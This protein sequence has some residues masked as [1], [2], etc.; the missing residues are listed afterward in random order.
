MTVELYQ[1]REG[2][3]PA[4]GINARWC[5]RKGVVEVGSGVPWAPGGK[6]EMSQGVLQI[7]DLRHAWGPVGF[8]KKNERCF[9]PFTVWFG[10]YTQ[11]GIAKWICFPVQWTAQ[12][13]LSVAK[14]TKNCKVLCHNSCQ[15]RCRNFR[16]ELSCSRTCSR[17][18]IL[19]AQTQQRKKWF[20]SERRFLLFIESGKCVTGSRE[21]MEGSNLEGSNLYTQWETEVIEEIPP[22]PLPIS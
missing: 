18:G 19:A 5:V 20:H 9:Y 1:V 13:P 11:H 14:C 10:N 21:V 22:H 2:F 16:A 8:I 4:S 17:E 7:C 6:K 3:L 15:Q 12:S